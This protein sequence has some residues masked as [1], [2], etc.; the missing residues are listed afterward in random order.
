MKPVIIVF[1]VIVLVGIAFFYF[2][3]PSK[4]SDVQF[5]VVSLTSRDLKSKLYIKKKVWGMTSDNQLV[6]LSNSK[7]KVFT[8]EDGKSYIY[9]GVMPLFFKQ[10]MDTIFIY[11]LKLAPVPKTFKTDFKV[12]QVFLENPDMMKLIEKDNFKSQGLV[13]I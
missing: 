13:K 5:S 2:S 8:S 1:A 7:N 11:T 3:Y 10:Q 9:D 6:V 12:I 4:N